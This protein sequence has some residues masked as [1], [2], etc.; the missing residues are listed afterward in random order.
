MN[1]ALGLFAVVATFRG[2]LLFP[3]RP[4]IAPHRSPAVWGF[5]LPQLCSR[6]PAPYS[7]LTTAGGE[8]AYRGSVDSLTREI[9]AGEMPERT[10]PS[11]KHLFR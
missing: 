7:L 2:D 9:S 1:E 10:A 4:R 6:S 8:N 11:A 3:F 5:S